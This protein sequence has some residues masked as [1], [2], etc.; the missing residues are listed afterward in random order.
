MMAPALLRGLSILGPQDLPGPDLALEFGVSAWML[1]T[2]TD[3]AGVRGLLPALRAAVLEAAGMDA[4]HEPVPFVG[5]S[6]RDDVVRS[7]GYLAEL[8]ARAAAAAG[9]EPT[10][11]AERAIGRLEVTEVR[12]EPVQELARIIP[13][14]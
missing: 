10:E 1:S 14:R 11:I 7:V 8:L 13:L 9:C 5:R 12:P 3:V 6:H 2:Q 4:A